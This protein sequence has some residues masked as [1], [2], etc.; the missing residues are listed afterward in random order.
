MLEELKQILNNLYVKYGL[1]DDI[2]KLS[3][4]IDKLIVGEINGSKTI[5]K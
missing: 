3:Q 2:I 4:F 1:I 5:S